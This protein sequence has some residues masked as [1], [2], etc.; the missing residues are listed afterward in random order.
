MSVYKVIKTEFRSLE[1]LKAALADM[2]V[3]YKTSLDGRGAD[4]ALYGYIN[5][6]RPERAALVIR[7]GWLNTHW[8]GMTPERPWQGMSNDIGFAW[9]AEARAYQGIVSEYD[10]TACA[11]NLNQLRQRYAYHEVHRLARA[12]GYNVIASE[13]VDGHIRIKIGRR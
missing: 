3:Q 5:D 2:G 9:D 10:Q 6:Q 4:L 11:E 12:K 8:S 7:R 13:S 1:S